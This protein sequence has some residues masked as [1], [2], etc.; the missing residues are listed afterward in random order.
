[1]PVENAEVVPRAQDLR[2]Q[3]PKQGA[4]MNRKPFVLALLCLTL[5]ALA[6]CGS[7]GSSA[8]LAVRVTEG[9][10]PSMMPG[11]TAPLVA[12][13]VN[14]K[15]NAGV[16]WS[17]APVNVCGSFSPGTTGFA[18]ATTYT[19][20]ATAP[21]GTISLPV[22]I[23]ANSVADPSQSASTS[24]VVYLATP[25][26]LNGQYAI[27]LQ[28]YNSNLVGSVTLDGNGNVT[29]GEADTAGLYTSYITVP[30]ISG[31]YTLDPTGHG[32][33]ALILG[34]CGNLSETHAITAT[35]S[36][37]V[38][39]SEA[40]QFWGLTIGG[41][42]SM[43][44]QTAGPNFSAAQ[45]SGGYSFTLTGFDGLA[46]EANGGTPNPPGLNA[47]WGG[48][49]TA[50]GVGTI[51]NGILDANDAGG[52]PSYYSTPFV[53]SFT[54]PDAYG[55]GTIS[56]NLNAGTS[57]VYYMVTPE[58]L[59]LTTA[60]N[61][62]NVNNA[63]SAYGQASAA[64]TDVALTGSYVFG[65]FGFD[66]QSVIQGFQFGG[67]AMAAAGQFKADGNGNIASGIMDLNDSG[68]TATGINIISGL[69]LAGS[70]YSIPGS[71]RGTFTGPS[72]QT[73][74]IY[75]TDPK[76]N[77][78]DP[79]NPSG[80]GGALLLE[81]DATFSTIGMAIPQAAPATATL[82]GTYAVFL[83]DQNNPPGY[84][85][86]LAGQFMAS[87][88]NPGTFSGEAA[89]Q[90]TGN[91]NATLVVG[92]LSG[93]FTADASNPGRF[94][95]T[96]TTAPCFP[97]YVPITSLTPCGVVT[98]FPIALQPAE[99]VSY[100]LASPA[101]GFVVE[102]DATAPVWGVVESQNTPSQ[103]AAA[104]K[105]RRANTQRTYSPS[106]IQ[107]PAG[108]WHGPRLGYADSRHE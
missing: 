55:R 88:A 32:T 84:G 49:F 75:L 96:I 9:L 76:L 47:S 99:N 19:A 2:A 104:A 65:D 8:P 28:G 15:N 26:L 50:D 21:A 80:G 105:R 89:F 22:T 106:P 85:G 67:D 72:G 18:V 35:S 107:Q 51:G 23:T 86:G 77:L 71:P 20:P 98:T 29:S 83:S 43:D 95:G 60:P 82:Q 87:S 56:T 48:I 53:G 90:G 61:A 69:S 94:T 54:A 41:V 39:I 34:C 78:L 10:P 66:A 52:A 101:Q 59:R 79:N 7:G 25:A 58:V 24:V 1:M 38:L 70:T 36:A 31:T 63:G 44:L 62:G 102:T 92:P 97:E 5:A 73:Y 40:D 74:N 68:D 108:E 93:T 91:N 13:V 33:L 6:A 37:H 27:I 17:C 64:T 42:G 11:A 45:L 57:Y 103:A 14:D 12:T 100:Y 46:V 16:T 3:L 4:Q 30:S 81:T